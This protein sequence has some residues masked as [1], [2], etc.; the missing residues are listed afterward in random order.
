MRALFRE[1][2]RFFG[3]GTGVLTALAIL[4]QMCVTLADLG[5][6]QSGLQLVA[7]AAAA[8]LCV[9]TFCLF[10]WADSIKD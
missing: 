5:S 6:G 9:I 8:L 10:S 3:Y 4:V 1:T 7:M 2:I